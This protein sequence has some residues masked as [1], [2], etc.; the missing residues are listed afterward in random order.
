MVQAPQVWS[1]KNLLRHLKINIG[2]FTYSLQI[3]R[4]PN[5][6]QDIHYTCTMY[7]K[8]KKQKKQKTGIAV[9]GAY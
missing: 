5:T 9:I 1:I 2:Y 7:H 6:Q 3:K 4:D 8:N